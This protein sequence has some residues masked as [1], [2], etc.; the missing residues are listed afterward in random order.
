MNKGLRKLPDYHQLDLFLAEYTDIATRA[1]QDLM[2]RPFFSLSKKPRF[3]AIRYSTDSADIIVSGGE[4]LGMANIW[5]ADILMW[6]ISQIVEARDRGEETSPQMYFTPYDCLRGVYRQ[7]GGQEYRLLGNAVQRL[8]NTVIHTN[9]R[10]NDQVPLTRLE[11]RRLERGFHWLEGYEIQSIER[12]GKDIPQGITIVLPNWLYRGVLSDKNILTIDERYFL[13]TSGLK[14]VL[15]MIA[16]KHVGD[17]DLWSFTMRQ[18]YE[19]TGS[20]SR[21]S[22]FASMIRRIV[23]END[24]PE[25]CMELHKGRHD[26]EV[27]TFIKRSRLD[28]KDPRYE[29]ARLDRRAQRIRMGLM[30]H[31]ADKDLEKLYARRGKN[32]RKNAE[33]FSA[34][35]GCE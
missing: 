6:I 14:R 21:F 25:Y 18:L 30:E 8:H 1:L 13:I 11:R 2:W 27:V 12:G 4:P 10:K 23:K 9:I 15:Y 17:Q 5:D 7:T 33:E 34:K 29:D 31:D 28:F 3:K 26:D 19:K 22:D 32:I 35:D 20:E 24:L 16:R